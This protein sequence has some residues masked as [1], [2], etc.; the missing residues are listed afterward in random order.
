MIIPKKKASERPDFCEDEHLDYLD[1]LKK[2]GVTN[3]FGA[4]PYLED[5]FDIEPEAA[6]E[7]LA[8]WMRTFTERHKNQR[9]KR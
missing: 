6:K 1:V 4:A 3:M 7:I 8:Y 5:E 2:S 9:A